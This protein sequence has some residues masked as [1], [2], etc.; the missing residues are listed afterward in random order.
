MSV[1]LYD[2]QVKL[3]RL[4][5]TKQ[6]GKSGAKTGEANWA[7][8]ADLVGRQLRHLLCHFSAII[9]WYFCQQKFY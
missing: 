3:E 5:K 9:S 7:T 1:P 2:A 8:Q 4:C 6:D